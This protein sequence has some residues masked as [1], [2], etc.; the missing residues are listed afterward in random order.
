MASV[1]LFN[2]ASSGGMMSEQPIAET[3]KNT[4]Q[5]ILIWPNI[6]IKGEQLILHNRQRNGGIHPV[7]Q[8]GK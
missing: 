4:Y 6:F 1:F 8:Y 3:K 2:Q 7:R 5:I